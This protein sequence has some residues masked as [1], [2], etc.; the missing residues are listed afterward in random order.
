MIK[1]I[2]KM[3]DSVR[4]VFLTGGEDIYDEDRNYY[5]GDYDDD[6]GHYTESRE[7]R[8]TARD[9][10]RHRERDTREVD[11]DR[12]D[13][14][15]DPMADHYTRGGAARRVPEK[16]ARSRTYQDKVNELGYASQSST[17]SSSSRRE[18]RNLSPHIVITHPKKIADCTSICAALCTG[19]A[20]SV[21]LSG[22]DS[23][24]AQRIADYLGGVI[25]AEQGVTMK[26]SNSVFILAPPGFEVYDEEEDGSKKPLG[27]R[28]F[29]SFGS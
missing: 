25:H 13:Y 15:D 2:Q 22:T 1:F 24:N 8:E 23:K 20:V 21:D 4:K 12:H 9:S 7:T 27:S 16:T 17:F 11:R 5:E 14:D 6:D 19:K 28:D 26:S 10:R 18:G 29:A 3:A